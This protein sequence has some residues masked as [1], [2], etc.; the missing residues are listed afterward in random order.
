MIRCCSYYFFAQS[1]Y[2]FSIKFAWK[3]CFKNSASTD[4][5]VPYGPNQAGV[6]LGT[7][8]RCLH[9]VPYLTKRMFNMIIWGESKE[10]HT[11]ERK[12]KGSSSEI[13]FSLPPKKQLNCWLRT[14]GCSVF[15]TVSSPSTEETVNGRFWCIEQQSELFPAPISGREQH[16]S[17]WPF[18]KVLWQKYFAKTPCLYFAKAMHL[19]L[20]ACCFGPL[21]SGT[22]C[23]HVYFVV[24]DV[25]YVVQHLAAWLSLGTI[26]HV[27]AS[28]QEGLFD[29]LKLWG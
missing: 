18:Q 12:G 5:T 28:I 17:R 14:F 13:S 27:S 15:A 25:G 10:Y 7:V 9:T 1:G 8:A 23:I 2:F 22:L 4:G 3:T 24:G 20:L 6:S 11:D 26:D 16:A 21:I 29:K 19:T